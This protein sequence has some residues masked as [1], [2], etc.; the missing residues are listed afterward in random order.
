MPVL[1]E[2]IPKCHWAAA[3]RESIKLQLLEAF[4]NLGRGR[5]ALTD[6]CEITLNISHEDGHAQLAE[7]FRED[8]QGNGFAGARRTGD[9]AVPIGHLREEK[10]SSFGCGDQ[11]VFGTHKCVSNGVL[12]NVTHD[13]A[14]GL[15]N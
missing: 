7:V 8:L 11:N 14:D 3:E 15:F 9:Q 1:A 2:H 5:T 13:S 4:L 10:N 6:A 12:W